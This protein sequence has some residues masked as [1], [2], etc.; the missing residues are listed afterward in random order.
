MHNFKTN[1]LY[2]DFNLRIIDSISVR[3]WNQCLSLTKRYQSKLFL[4]QESYNFVNVDKDEKLQATFL[5]IVYRKLS[6]QVH[7]ICKNMD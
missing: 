4:K 2:I 6:N 3:L 7:H 5:S 1:I